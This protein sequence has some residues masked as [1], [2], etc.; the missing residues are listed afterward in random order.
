MEDEERESLLQ[1]CTCLTWLW[2]A[3]NNYTLTALSV[4]SWLDETRRLIFLIF[5]FRNVHST[6]SLLE[7]NRAKVRPLE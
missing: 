6:M 4:A 7:H 2:R 1:W 3:M 5:F